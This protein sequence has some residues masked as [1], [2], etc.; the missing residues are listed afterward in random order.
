MLLAIDI[1]NTQAVFGLWNGSDW[2]VWRKSTRPEETEDELAAW[3]SSLFAIAGIPFS[4]DGVAVASVVPQMNFAID[5][6]AKKWL[7][8]EPF[9]LTRGEQIG[10]TVRY[11]PPHAVGADRLANAL[12]AKSQLPVPIVVV[13]FGT[14][15]TFDA[16]DRNGDYAGGAILPG[17]EVSAQALVGRTAKLPQFELE[18]PVKAIGSTTVSSL[19]SGVMLGYAAAIEG[20]A[21]QM[22]QE[23]GMGTQVVSTGGLGPLFLERCPTIQEY[24]PNLTLDGLRLAYDLSR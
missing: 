2:R 15:T 9:F 4:V 10:L 19:Q 14:A 17:I 18:F 6:L 12:A 23:L 16:V 13:D 8:R 1:G 24:I 21:C 5:H 7:R 22:A 3:L 20:I 11:D